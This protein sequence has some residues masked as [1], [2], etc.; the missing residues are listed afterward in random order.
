MPT[1]CMRTFYNA[2]LEKGLRTSNKLLHLRSSNKFY[3]TC[4]FTQANTPNKTAHKYVTIMA[5]KLIGITRSYFITTAT[6]RV[7]Q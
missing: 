5:H 7:Y 6:S 2:Q 3:H 1:P 4:L